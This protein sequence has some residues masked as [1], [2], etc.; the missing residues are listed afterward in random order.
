MTGNNQNKEEVIL[1]KMMEFVF[2]FQKSRIL[3]TA[4]ELDLFTTIGENSK[5][6]AEVSVIAGTDERAVNRLMNALCVMGLLEKNENKFSNTSLTSQ[7]LIKGKPTYAAGIM[8]AVHL[9]ENW[10]IWPFR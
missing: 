2:A 8:H 9:W 1:E 3:F 10:K 6:S 5:T 7:F 4:F